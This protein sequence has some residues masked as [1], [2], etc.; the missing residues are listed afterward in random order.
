MFCVASIVSCQHSSVD[1]GTDP[2]VTP[3]GVAYT[4]EDGMLVFR[5]SKSMRQQIEQFQSFSDKELTDWNA[6]IGFTS[7]YEQ[8]I[9][10]S[11][12]AA[13]G[14]SGSTTD[15]QLSQYVHDTYLASLLNEAG[16]FAI[17][18]RVIRITPSIVFIGPKSK[19]A[20][21]RKLDPAAYN[22][23]AVGRHIVENGIT[24]GKAAHLAG[25]LANGRLAF[26]G[27]DHTIFEY[28]GSHRVATVIYN[29]NWYVYRS[30][31][32]KVKFQNKR[33]WGGWWEDNTD[34]LHMDYSVIYDVSR[35][36]GVQQYVTL[37]LQGQDCQEC[38]NITHTIDF[39]I[40]EMGVSDGDPSVNLIDSAF[41]FKSFITNSSCLYAGNYHTDQLEEDQ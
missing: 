15:A 5:D 4:V 19:L 33:W 17:G 25:P 32:T 41:D 23:L 22:S 27:V 37:H 28:D 7:V 20:A 13:S 10:S 34:A 30:L 40:A 18:K 31:G 26:N 12:G 36:T 9:Q 29:D 6:T 2:A 8:Q 35:V 24:I 11:T 3:S 39:D 16:E 38:G 1:P 14:R 21:I